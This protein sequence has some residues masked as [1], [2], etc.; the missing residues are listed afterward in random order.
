MENILDGSKA[1]LTESLLLLGSHKKEI[2]IVGGWGP[3][4]R[5][6]NEHPGTNDIDI[7]FPLSYSKDILLKIIDKFLE[8]NFYISSKNDFQ[9]CRAYKIGTRTYIYNVDLLHPKEGKVNKVD[10]VNIMDLDVT[11]DGIRVK[12]IASITMQ[13]GDVVYSNNLIQQIE[14]EGKEFNVLD[15]AGIVISKINS[16]HNRKRERDIFD[17]YLS[18]RE[19]ETIEKLKSLFQVNPIIEESFI[20]YKTKIKRDWDF[21]RSSLAK[22]NIKDDNAQRLLLIDE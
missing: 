13:F 16:C 9:L 7:L 10:F 12:P 14:F 15:G 19:N 21:Y 3:Y 22:F 2:V 8:N 17:I 5:H 18:L 11:V 1:L 6:L 20:D 4:I